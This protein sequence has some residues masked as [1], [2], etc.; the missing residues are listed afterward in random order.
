MQT[1]V[2]I[3]VSTLVLLQPLVAVKDNAE[4][5]DMTIEVQHWKRL[6]IIFGY[7]D[8]VKNEL[9]ERTPIN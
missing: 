4:D 6:K 1:L 9:E 8:Y 7:F 5:H 2:A 3:K